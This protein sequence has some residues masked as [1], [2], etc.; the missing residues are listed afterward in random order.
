[1]LEYTYN[2]GLA[3]AK[4]TNFNWTET[5]FDKNGN[6]WKALKGEIA[7]WSMRRSNYFSKSIKWWF[8]AINISSSN[9]PG[10]RRFRLALKIIEAELKHL[11]ILAEDAGGWSHWDQIALGA[12][13]GTSNNKIEVRLGKVWLCLVMFGWVRLG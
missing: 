9:F 12:D 6:S 10:S 7:T 5:V 1:M 3:Q 11:S 4:A 2:M 8:R 13:N